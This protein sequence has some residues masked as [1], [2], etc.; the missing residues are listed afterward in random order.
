MIQ[1]RSREGE[2]R[3]NPNRGCFEVGRKCR[4]SCLPGQQ[5]Q[6]CRGEALRDVVGMPFLEV[7]E[8]RMGEFLV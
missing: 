6:R 2:R 8:E 4:G 7:V 1:I 3:G 5:W